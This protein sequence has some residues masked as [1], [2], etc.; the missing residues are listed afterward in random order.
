MTL[1][2]SFIYEPLSLKIVQKYILKECSPEEG[3][4]TRDCFKDAFSY[5][6][7]FEINFRRMA[8][9][10]LFYFLSENLRKLINLVK[11]RSNYTILL[12]SDYQI[13]SL[14]FKCIFHSLEKKQE[15]TQRPRDLA[16]LVVIWSQPYVGFV[17]YLSSFLR[18]HTSTL[19][20]RKSQNGQ[21]NN[22]ITV[23]SLWA[24]SQA[25]LTN[26]INKQGNMLLSKSYSHHITQDASLATSE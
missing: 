6:N 21:K 19:K 15:I 13:Q 12:Q 9:Q 25:T 24:L 17:F 2:D 10:F 16:A 11:I 1:L 26:K 20:K 22:T 8:D 4:D 3:N 14:N 18:K 7:S 23:K 5:D